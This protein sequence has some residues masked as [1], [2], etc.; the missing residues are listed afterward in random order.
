MEGKLI[1]N[2]T[3]GI[4]CDNMCGASIQVIQDDGE[5]LWAQGWRKVGND[6]A[7]KDLCP[8]CFEKMFPETI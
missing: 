2:P 6:L 1:R 5:D 4:V 8:P 7:Q 3:I